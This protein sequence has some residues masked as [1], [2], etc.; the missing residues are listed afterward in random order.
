M[1]LQRAKAVG[2]DTGRTAGPVRVSCAIPTVSFVTPFTQLSG[3]FMQMFLCQTK[4]EAEQSELK[5]S[6]PGSLRSSYQ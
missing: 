3:A 4:V 5:Q 6:G 2:P 1:A